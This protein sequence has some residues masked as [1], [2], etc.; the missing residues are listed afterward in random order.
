MTL[1]KVTLFREPRDFPDDEL[2]VLASQGL[3]ER[4]Y[5]AVPNG[6]SEAALVEQ[7]SKQKQ[8]T[9]QSQ[10]QGS[11]HKAGKGEGDGRSGLCP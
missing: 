2:A 4:V 9:D 8:D 7:P 10:E 1:A 5:K 3:V 11:V 6:Q